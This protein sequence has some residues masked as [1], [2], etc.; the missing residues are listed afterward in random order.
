MLFRSKIQE[1]LSDEESMQ[2]IKELADMLSSS[3]ESPSS[4]ESN[5]SSQQNSNNDAFDGSSSSD[6]SD[7]GGFGFDFGMLFKIQELMSATK[8]DKNSELIMA[9]RPHLSTEKQAKA[10]K[11]IK[12][13]KLFAIWQTLKESGMLNDLDKLL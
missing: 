10:D 7:D 13:M 5:N 6:S 4:E 8:G 2:Q 11:A 12:F 3:A 9:L 1:M